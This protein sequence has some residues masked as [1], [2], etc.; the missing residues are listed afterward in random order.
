[1]K[2]AKT[3][4]GMLP[5]PQDIQVKRNLFKIRGSRFCAFRT[6]RCAKSVKFPYS[7]P[8][9]PYTPVI[10]KMAKTRKSGSAIRKQIPL[11]LDI[12]GLG[13]HPLQSLSTFHRVV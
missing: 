4:Q 12:L 7:V 8:I 9:G 6:A 2:S 3:L 1:M 10:Q 5:Q 11:N 13:E